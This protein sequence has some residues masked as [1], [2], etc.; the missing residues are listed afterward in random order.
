MRKKK[1]DPN[2]QLKVNAIR[3]G[4]MD[5]IRSIRAGKIDDIQLDMLQNFV[6]F[7]LALMEIEGPEKWALAKLN[8]EIMSLNNTK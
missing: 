6:L 5:A 4:A 3:S 7:S 2:W 1:V 8:A